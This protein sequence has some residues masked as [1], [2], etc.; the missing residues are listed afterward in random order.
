[1]SD[2]FRILHDGREVGQLTAEHLE[3]AKKLAHPEFQH[4]T[5]MVDDPRLVKMVSEGK[6]AFVLSMARGYSAEKVT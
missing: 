6:T 5:E 2:T 1:M 4:T 3:F